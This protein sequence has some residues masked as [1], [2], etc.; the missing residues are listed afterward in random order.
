MNMPETV[1]TRTLNIL[2]RA[3]SAMGGYIILVDRTPNQ[4]WQQVPGSA[5]TQRFVTARADEHSLNLSEWY[6]GHYFDTLSEALADFNNRVS[7][8]RG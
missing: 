6:Y 4:P 7:D 1:A 5:Y 3:E 8:Y 2:M